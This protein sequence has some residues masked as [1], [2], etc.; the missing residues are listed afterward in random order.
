MKELVCQPIGLSGALS[1]LD[2]SISLV[3]ESGAWNLNE[4]SHTV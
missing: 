3:Q 4:Y 1:I 2:T